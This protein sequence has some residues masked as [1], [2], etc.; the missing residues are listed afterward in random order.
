MKLPRF[1]RFLKG[2]VGNTDAE[3]E[4]PPRWTE[5]EMYEWRRQRNAQWK[6]DQDITRGHFEVSDPLTADEAEEFQHL[7]T[8]YELYEERRHTDDN[9][10]T[11]SEWTLRDPDMR[12]RFEFL[13]NKQQAHV[14]SLS[15]Q[16]TRLPPLQYYAVKDQILAHGLGNVYVRFMVDDGFCY[17]RVLFLWNFQRYLTNSVGRAAKA[18]THAGYHI[19]LC[20]PKHYNRDATIK[21]AV[22]AYGERFRDFQMV[23]INDVRISSGDTY[24]II[25]NSDFARGLREIVA[26]SIPDKENYTPHISLD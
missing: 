8:N 4:E 24:E 20:Y 1:N 16:Q 7:E 2:G 9:G 17:L 3:M 10:H 21:A 15:Y 19:T 22:D 25:G 5:D 14:A 18:L 26:I 13:Q 12:E 23:T 11:W 6:R